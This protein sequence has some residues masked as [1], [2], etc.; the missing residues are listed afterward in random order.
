M[1]N[2]QH[3]LASDHK[4]WTEFVVAQKDVNG[5]WLPHKYNAKGNGYMDE[6]VGKLMD[7]RIH[8]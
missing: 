3:R 2:T 5:K 4:I 6:S 1:D 7:G 8:S